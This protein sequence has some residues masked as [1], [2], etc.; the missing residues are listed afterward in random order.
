MPIFADLMY[1][2]ASDV[3][4]HANITTPHDAFIIFPTLVLLIFFYVRDTH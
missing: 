2:L 1:G 4:A 3:L